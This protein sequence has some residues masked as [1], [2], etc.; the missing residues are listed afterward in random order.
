MKT[1]IHL[2]ICKRKQ[3]L[4][5][6]INYSQLIMRSWVKKGDHVVLGLKTNEP[7]DT[8]A[9]DTAQIVVFCDLAI[10]LTKITEND[11]RRIYVASQK[12]MRND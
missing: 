2:A 3:I 7:F 1:Y 10:R 5:K 12:K 4:S 6:L 8:S 11:R 9:T